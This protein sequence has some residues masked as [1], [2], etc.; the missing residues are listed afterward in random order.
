M[1]YGLSTKGNRDAVSKAIAESNLPDAAKSFTA[2]VAAGLAAD[3]KVVSV[4][5]SG[6]ADETGF[7][8]SFNLGREAEQA[9]TE[10]STA[11]VAAGEQ[12]KEA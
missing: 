11:K 8:G 1:T 5:V 10:E 6:H 12:A 9:A 3:G 2:E 7:S 4:S